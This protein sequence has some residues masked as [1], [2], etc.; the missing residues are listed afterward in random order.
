MAPIM[1]PIHRKTVP[2]TYA[3]NNL[4]TSQDRERPKPEKARKRARNVH[5]KTP[6][7]LRID[8][9]TSTFTSP[10]CSL[11]PEGFAQWCKHQKSDENQ[12]NVKEN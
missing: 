8:V 4:R 3:E 1:L 6:I 9:V 7:W 2:G 10:F 5:P 12:G 11:V